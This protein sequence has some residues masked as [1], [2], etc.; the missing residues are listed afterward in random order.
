MLIK[1]ADDTE[2]EIIASGR[3]Q[4]EHKA[5][6]RGQSYDLE[7]VLR[8]ELTLPRPPGYRMWEKMERAGDARELMGGAVVQTWPRF[9]DASLIEEEDHG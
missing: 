3:T 6:S 8:A 1:F 7:M 9:L 5:V 4:N 2:L